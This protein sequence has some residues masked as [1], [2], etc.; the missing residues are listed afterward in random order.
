VDLGRGMKGT[1]QIYVFS[2]ALSEGE[3]FIE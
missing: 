3:G 1:F 2:E